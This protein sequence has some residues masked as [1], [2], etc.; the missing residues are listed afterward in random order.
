MKY[1][2]VVVRVG[3]QDIAISGID[4]ERVMTEA[5]TLAAHLAIK[6]HPAR[7]EILV[8]DHVTV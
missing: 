7:A 5:G 8:M 1:T 3:P 2:R 6:Y 4:T